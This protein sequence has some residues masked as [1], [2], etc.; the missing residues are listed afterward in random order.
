MG[1]PN[2][3]V[4]HASFHHLRDEEESTVRRR[5]VS[6][7]LVGDAAIRDLVGSP[8]HRHWDDRRHRFDASHI[9]FRQLLDKRQNSVE[10]I[11]QMT[12]FIISNGYSGQPCDSADRCSVH[13]HCGVPYRASRIAEGRLARQRR[14]RH[15]PVRPSQESSVP[16]AT[17]IRL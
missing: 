5:R 4:T 13:G 3:I 16:W 2:N 12:D 6:E 17:A 14:P 7:D 11:L 9:D 15:L 8:I 10:L 1:N